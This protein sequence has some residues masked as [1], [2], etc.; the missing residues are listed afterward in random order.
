MSFQQVIG[1]LKS[2]K[3]DPVYVMV[4]QE[5][6]L[7]KEFEK[8]LIEAVIGSKEEVN[9]FNW[10]KIDLEEW[11]LE[12]A[13]VEANTVSF[14]S[15][16]K[17]IWIKNPAFLSSERGKREE[18]GQVLLDY[19]HSPAEGVVVVFDC[20]FEK[21]DGRKKLVKDLKK[22]ATLVDVGVVDE[23]TVTT[24]V[25]DYVRQAGYAM[26]RQVLQV[27]LE[28]INYEL[29]KAMNELDKI[30]LFVGETDKITKHDVETVVVPSLDNNIF[31]LP[32]FVMTKRL[33]KALALYRT[34]VLEKQQPIAILA[35]LLSN[36]RLYSQIVL[37]NQAGYDQ[38]AIA[39]TLSVH[40]YR[41]K[42][43]AK[44][45]ARYASQEIL[46][47]YEKL[48]DLDYS[49]KSGQVEANLG[50]EY[51]ILRFSKKV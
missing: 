47:A 18:N 20:N 25:K 38:G 46:L 40:P 44:Q 34:L 32:D 22:V 49:I 1:A 50:I 17:V 42:M 9:D 2:R 26:D 27:F 43:G 10:V 21:L 28:R 30:F 14:F 15:E 51:F 24:Y 48:V 33:D 36:F 8:H 37:L 3:V 7:Q 29:S 4:G 35:L 12:D 41:I 5:K 31:H 13:M 39:Q 19:V 6:H 11:T 23:R 16:P 45:V